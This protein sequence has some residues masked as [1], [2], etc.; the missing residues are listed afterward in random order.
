MHKCALIYLFLWEPPDTIF[1]STRCF[2]CL[3]LGIRVRAS[4]AQVLCCASA[5]WR[6]LSVFHTQ[7]TNDFALYTEAIKFFNH[8]ESMV[9]IAVRTITLNVYKGEWQRHTCTSAS[10][11]QVST[12][13]CVCTH[14]HTLTHTKGMVGH[15]F[16]FWKNCFPSLYCVSMANRY[17]SQRYS[18][19]QSQYNFLS[20][21]KWFWGMSH[22]HITKAHLY[23]KEM[24]IYL[25]LLLCFYWPF[26]FYVC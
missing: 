11:T 23:W 14:A 21:G 18:P 12:C 2:C 20:C 4:T 15:H 10:C 25:L 26:F 5:H 1:D 9:R 22:S 3:S 19:K 13:K 17:N 16:C 7:H 8:P 24:S 6:P